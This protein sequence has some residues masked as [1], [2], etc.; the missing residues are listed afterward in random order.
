MLGTTQYIVGGMTPNGRNLNR[1][2]GRDAV[3][4]ELLALRDQPTGTGV[5]LGVV[6]LTDGTKVYEEDYRA[7]V[8][9]YMTANP[10]TDLVDALLGSPGDECLFTKTL[11]P[12]LPR[13]QEC[14]DY[15]AGTS[16]GED[17]PVA[18]VQR[19]V[20]DVHAIADTLLDIVTN[21]IGEDKREREYK[22]LRL[23]W[24]E[25]SDTI[26]NA[27]KAVE[28][29]HPALVSHVVF[30][31]VT[32]TH[33]VVVTVPATD[34]EHAHDLIQRG[35]NNVSSVH[36]LDDVFEDVTTRGIEVERHEVQE[37]RKE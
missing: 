8:L 20:F 22:D 10:V 15:D 26:D 6:T 19:T 31:E 25:M 2:N 27:I 17:G 4:T 7:A 18:G 24:C 32:C 28:E 36:E 14:I 1:A 11:Y 21:R 13:M 29:S 23:T 33:R 5:D 3:L 35:M 9:A 34:D 30:V 12:K 16:I 37:I